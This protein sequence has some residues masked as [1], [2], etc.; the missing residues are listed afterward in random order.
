M[1]AVT[2]AAHATD[3]IANA[4]TTIGFRLLFMLILGSA[5]QWRGEA[6]V[7]ATIDDVTQVSAG[8]RS[9]SPFSRVLQ[10]ASDDRIAAA[11]DRL[12]RRR[13]PPTPSPKHRTKTNPNSETG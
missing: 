6:L 13:T 9:M 2:N 8:K 7:V 10:P 12:G 3:R 5:P 4:R 11:R 1:A